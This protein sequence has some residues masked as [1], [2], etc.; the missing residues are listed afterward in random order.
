MSLDTVDS[1]DEVGT[2]DEGASDSVT[3]DSSGTSRIEGSP[4]KSF[5]L[6][7]I[8]DEHLFP[9][10]S[11]DSDEA[12]T[13]RIVLDSID[14]FMEPKGPEYRTYDE[15]GYQPETYIESLKELGLFGL[16]IPEEYGGL[17]FSNLAYSRVIQQ[18]SRFDASTS[19]TIGAHSSIGMKGLLLFGNANQKA[20]YLPKLATG[21]MVASFC[22]TEPGSGSDAASIKTTA[23]KNADGSWS[24]SGE[25][26]WITNGA[27]ASFFTVFARTDGDAGKLSAFIVE[28]AWDGVSTGPKEDK[29]GIRASATTSV[30]FDKVNVPAENLL[31]EEGKGFKIAM[32][33]LNNGRT[34]LGGGCVGGMKACIALAS[35]Q[36][37]ERKQF[38]QPIAE[39][40]LIKEKIAQM[41]VDC[42]AAESVV[43]MVGHYIDSGY[44]DCSVEAAISKVFNTEALWRT[45]NEALQIAA[46]NGYM[47][48]FPY[49]RIVRDSRINMIFEGTNEILRL[50]IA[51]SGMKD[52]G[53]YLKTVLKSAES[54]FNHPIKG[55]GVL[56]EYATKRFTQL[57]TVGRDRIVTVVAPQLQ[58]EAL[59]FEKYALELGRATDT[60]LRKH[61]K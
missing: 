4:V 23:S 58:D 47:K 31:G 50:Y 39:F 20:K 7:E 41:T 43:T 57:T 29:L 46:G 56:S 55:F 5:F 36:A 16:I 33:I 37:A 34:G 13:V 3:G 51:L 2:G 61:G 6:G 21:E 38:G 44:K 42:F 11:F 27:F 53:A 32:A 35:K 28:R 22:L 40:G 30:R 9:F 12:E 45:A 59:I 60:I 14:K 52:A 10:P 17:G 19:L 49:E 26:I 24:L 48:E 1:E 18:S 8:P 25:K 54:I 15:Q